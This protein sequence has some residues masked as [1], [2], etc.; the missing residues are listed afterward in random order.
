MSRLDKY[1]PSAVGVYTW[2]GGFDLG[3]SEFFNVVGYVADDKFASKTYHANFPDVPQ[4]L[5]PFEQWPREFNGK[6]PQLTYAAPPCSAWS[7]VGRSMFRG[8]DSWKSDPVA[9]CTHKYVRWG[10]EVQ[11]KVWVDESVPQILKSGLVEDVA[12]LWMDAGY[13]FTVIKFDAKFHGLP[14]QR[15]RVFLVAHQVSIP[16]A[17]PKFKS[18][19]KL[20]TAGEALELAPPR[21]V[22]PTSQYHIMPDHWIEALKAYD[23]HNAA[24]EEGLEKKK[25]GFREAWERMYLDTAQRRGRD[26]KIVV[27]RPPFM[28]GRIRPERPSHTVIGVQVYLHPYEPR[29]ITPREAAKLCGYPDDYVW[30]EETNDGL[31][32]AE[33]AKAVTPTAASWLAENLQRGIRNGTKTKPTFRILTSWGKSLKVEDNRL[34][35]DYVDYGN[36]I[37]QLVPPRP[38]PSDVEQLEELMQ[39]RL[40]EMLDMEEVP[41]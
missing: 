39:G 6:R 4:Y 1:K 41:A 29:L 7:P 19:E 31:T 12:R 2:A 9:D 22:E 20:N 10:L 38:E 11:P 30:A 36:D 16:W 13:A 26:D 40:D 15:R 8:K 14:Q 21:A 17:P 37:P 18:G 23:L 32:V 28:C 33:I 35:W 24:V 5:L 3:V 27:G 34:V 25:I